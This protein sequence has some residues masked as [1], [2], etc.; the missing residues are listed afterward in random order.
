[1]QINTGPSGSDIK[2]N[3]TAYEDIKGRGRDLGFRGTYTIYNY[4]KNA[5]YLM[6]VSWRIQL[7]KNC[8]IEVNNSSFDTSDKIFE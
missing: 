5:S 4:Y 7:E 1:L 2:L 6:P 8:D 3:I